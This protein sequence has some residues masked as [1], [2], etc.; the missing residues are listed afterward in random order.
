MYQFSIRLTQKRQMYLIF[1]PCMKLYFSETMNG[2]FGTMHVFD[3]NKDIA[4]PFKSAEQAKAHI[5]YIREHNAI[6]DGY[7]LEIVEV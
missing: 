5:A 1:D 2:A 3:Q 4:H 7:I 6:W